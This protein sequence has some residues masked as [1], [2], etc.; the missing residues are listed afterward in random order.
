MDTVASRAPQTQEA[1][2]VIT[3][4]QKAFRLEK[5]TGATE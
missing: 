1:V 5:V 2:T 3:A 4:I